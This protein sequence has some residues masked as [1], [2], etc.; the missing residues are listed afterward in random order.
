VQVLCRTLGV[1]PSGYYAWRSRPLCARAKADV[2]LARRLQ[3]VHAAHREVYGR[4]RLHRALRAEGICIGEKRVRRLMH[5]AAVIVR[6]HR[7]FRPTTQ[8]DHAWPI[9]PNL[10][11]RRFAIAEPARVWAADMTAF[12][13]PHGWGYLAVVLDL[14]SRRIVGWAV[15]SSLETALPLAALH[16][17]LAT[18]PQARWLLH[19]SDRGSQYASDA[20]QR[21]LRAYGLVP[22]MSRVGDCWDNAP[23]ESFFSGLKAEVS[24]TWQ[25]ID[26]MRAGLVD[27]LRFYNSQRLHSALNFR[28]PLDFEADFKTAV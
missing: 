5:V 27:Y 16:M 4:P 3:V 14:A 23:V 8:S 9:A 19:H 10:L 20:Y 18:R 12:P 11:D 6:R 1:T 28:S 13:L 15:R 25:T 17:A 22:S 2:Q 7:R 24:A 26:Q 21:T